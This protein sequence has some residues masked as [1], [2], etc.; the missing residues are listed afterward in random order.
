MKIN[1]KLIKVIVA[2]VIIIGTLVL[3]VNSITPQSYSGSELTFDVNSGDIVVTNLTDASIP[4]LFTGSGTRSFRVISDIEDVTGNSAREGSGSSSTHVFAFELPT[5]TSTFTIDRGK[6]VTFVATA[7][8]EIE[9]T[10]NNMSAGMARNAIIAAIVVVLAALF[11]ASRV[12]EHSLFHNLTS[13][14]FKQVKTPE[15]VVKS[16]QGN[17]ARSFGDNRANTGD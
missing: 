4:A 6:T 12:M 13:D 2:F 3:L 7:S 5:G 17:M 16:S 14:K 15:P 9:A 11:Y 1:G 8:G 10:V